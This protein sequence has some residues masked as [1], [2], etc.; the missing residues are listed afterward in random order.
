MI[1]SIENKTLKV[2]IDTLGAQL[3]SI[4]SK[5]T[6]REYLW[7]GE[8]E[9]WKGRAYNL[10]PT[11]GRMVDGIFIYKKTEYPIKPHGIA[12]YS[13]F[14]LFERT[15]T[16]ITFVLNADAE[17]QKVYPFLF[18]F[19]VTYELKN[20]ELGVT[21]RVK[22]NDEKLLIYA[23]G[24]H[25][26]FNVPFGEGEFEDYYLE[27]S[28]NSATVQHLLSENKFMSGETQAF[29]LEEGNKLSL[30]H[31]LFNFDAV[32]L[33][34]TSREVSLKSKEDGAYITFK[35]PYYRYLGLWHTPNMNAP[36]VCLEPWS[37]LP[38]KEGRVDDLE[39][40][41]VM[42]KLRTG[43]E[44]THFYSITVHEEE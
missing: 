13:E 22:N 31:A 7:Q 32:I 30:T 11:I 28:E 35:Y 38:A 44:K 3:Q 27:F 34:N 40:K 14:E 15:A 37:S 17:T 21:Y 4:Y 33:A 16:K 41:S 9:F 10:F 23:I 2:E 24:G 36:F 26:G 18:T 12:R 25:P 1:Y 20:N 43:Q 19:Y 8:P 29:P 39:K 6:G 42:N 5:C